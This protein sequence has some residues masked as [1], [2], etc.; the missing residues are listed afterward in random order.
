[1][2]LDPFHP[3]LIVQGSELSEGWISY[4]FGQKFTYYA[5]VSSDPTPP[6]ME[7]RQLVLI[8]SDE[9]GR[10]YDPGVCIGGPLKAN[11]PNQSQSASGQVRLATIGEV[12]FDAGTGHNYEAIT[13]GWRQL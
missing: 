5:T 6:Y 7:G 3:C 11:G 1:V 10:D 8:P 13:G 12:L 9:R 4:Y 2:P